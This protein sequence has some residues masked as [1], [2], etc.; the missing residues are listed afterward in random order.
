MGIRMFLILVGF[1]IIS[2]CGQ[3]S[4]N[5]QHKQYLSNKGWEVKELIEVKTYILDIPNEMLS[6]YE[7]SGITF[8]GDYLGKEVTSYIYELKEKDVEGKRLK[9]VVFEAEEEIIGGYG[10][11]PS[12]SPGK[13][14]LDDKERLINEKMIKQ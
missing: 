13:F 9:S 11:L 8:F 7:A 3:E 2:G 4:L 10:L 12:W 6:G 5:E 1:L 14:N